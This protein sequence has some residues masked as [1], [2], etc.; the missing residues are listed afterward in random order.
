[1]H[2]TSVSLNNGVAMPSLGFGT[3]RVGRGA[4]EAALA[5]GYR[6]I[7]TAEMYGN[8]EEVGA[9]IAASGVAREDLFVTTKVWNDHHGHRATLDAFDASRRR[10]GLDVVDLYLIHW[11]QP[12]LGLHAETWRALEELY[13][14]GAMRAIGVSNF[15]PEQIE[16][17]MAGAEVVP[18]VNQIELNPG[19]SRVRER[20]FHARHGIATEAWA[21]IARGGLLDD[22][23]ITAVAEEHGR[24]PAQ[25]IL[26]WHLQHGV[27]AIP[28]SSKPERIEQNLAIG[29]FELDEREMKALDALDSD[30][31][32]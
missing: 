3:W 26:R 17:L 15:A 25:V 28:R 9:A 30:A 27:I 12:S 2:T 21:P 11:P 32:R 4:V 1:M 16:E 23:A 14:D 19:R 7:D 8:E 10:L 31:D 5:A 29:D 24:T 13:A 22:A 18:A 6:S 20:A